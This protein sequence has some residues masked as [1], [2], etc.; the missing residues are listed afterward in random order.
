MREGH[1]STQNKSSIQHVQRKSAISVMQFPSESRAALLAPEEPMMRSVT[2]APPRTA[3]KSMHIVPPPI[4][5]E[6]P[7]KL[8]KSPVVDYKVGEIIKSK[9]NSPTLHVSNWNVTNV[10]LK[11]VPDYHILERTSRFIV[12]TTVSVISA[13]ISDCLRAR[14]IETSFN[15]DKAK[16][17]CSNSDCI[18]FNIRLYSGRG[19][20]NHGIIVEVQRRSGSSPSFTK[21]CAAV[22]DA[23]EGSV[24]EESPLAKPLRPVE[25]LACVKDLFIK[26]RMLG[27]PSVE[28][29]VTQIPFDLLTDNRLDANILG[30]DCLCSLTDV[31]YS[32]QDMAVQVSQNIFSSSNR[33]IVEKILSIMRDDRCP[34]DEEDPDADSTL[35]S[36]LRLLALTVIVNILSLTKIDSNLINIKSQSV[37]D[38]D[39]ISVLVECLKNSQGHCFE[40]SIA[41]KGLSILFSSAYCPDAKKKMQHIGGV[42]AL[43]QAHEYGSKYHSSLAKETEI[44]LHALECH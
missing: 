6:C 44:C 32:T 19:D 10:S 42:A 24:C 4:G 15:D 5:L 31:N 27:E 9:S 43:Y 36:K 34:I 2:L 21:D 40:A 11:C 17:R 16:A 41:A 18:K 20:Y 14:S 3:L 12:G 13:R 7:Q 25:E 22:L 33:K 30:M 1:A 37:F 38:D 23:A 8:K 26:P 35:Y 29:D 39:L 28:T